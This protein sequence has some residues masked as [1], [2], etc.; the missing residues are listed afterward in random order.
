V[1]DTFVRALPYA[2]RDVDAPEGTAIV[3]RIDDA[4]WSLVRDDASWHLYVG[5]ADSPTTAVS[6]SGDAAWRVFTKQNIDPHASIEG[7]A[8]YAEPLLRMIA[9]VA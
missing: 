1:L 5:A 8:R 6:I 2:Y 9:I 7:D 4:A 3:L